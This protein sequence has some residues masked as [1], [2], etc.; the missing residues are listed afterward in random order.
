MSKR[1]R[2]YLDRIEGKV[3]V[4]FLGEREEDEVHL[5]KKYLPSGAREGDVLSISIQ[6]DRAAT[7]AARRDAERLLDQMAEER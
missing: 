4:L 6:V 1:V 2:A 5:P 3:A 7:E